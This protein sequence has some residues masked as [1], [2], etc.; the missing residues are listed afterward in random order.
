M[1]LYLG[2]ISANLQHT[3]IGKNFIFAKKHST[4]TSSK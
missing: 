4:F 1:T 2:L 3:L